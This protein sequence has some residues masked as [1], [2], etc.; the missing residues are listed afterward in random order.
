MT[1]PT[2]MTYTSVNEP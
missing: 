1:K 2:H